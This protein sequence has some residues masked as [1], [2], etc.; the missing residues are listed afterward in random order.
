M[1]ANVAALE[2]GYKSKGNGGSV[3]E[4]IQPMIL[5]SAFAGECR[6]THA[7]RLSQKPKKCCGCREKAPQLELPPSQRAYMSATVLGDELS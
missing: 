1:G 6:G 2:I 5:V 7:K 4:I 3:P